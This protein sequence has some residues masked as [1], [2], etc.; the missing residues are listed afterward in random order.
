MNKKM[1]IAVLPLTIFIGLCIVFYWSL[2]QDPRELETVR[3]GKSVPDFSLPLLRNPEKVVSAKDLPKKPFLLNVWGTWCGSC[4]AEHPYLVKFSKEYSYPWIGINYKDK[5][6]D[7]LNY[8]QKG[9]DPYLYSIVDKKGLLAIDLG[10]YGAPETFIVDSRGIIRERH[11]GE[12]N[13][14]VWQ[15]KILPIMQKLEAE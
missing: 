2:Q 8:L 9:G 6:Q 7:A 10:V 15:D 13:D 14:R 1:L 3:Q 12:I 4:Y 11:V 5:A